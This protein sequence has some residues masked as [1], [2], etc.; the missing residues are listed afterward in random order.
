MRVRVVLFGRA[1]DQAGERE[2]T[3]E[4]P[5]GATMRAVADCLVRQ[6]PQLDWLRRISRPARNLEYV[7]WNDLAAAED[8]ISFIRPVSGDSG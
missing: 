3:L 7:S 2:V 5:E 1:A 6:Y 4:V 8:E